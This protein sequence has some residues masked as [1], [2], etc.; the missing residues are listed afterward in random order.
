VKTIG[1]TL[2]TFLNKV[3]AP[4]P[5]QRN[6]ILGLGN[7]T[8]GP[9]DVYGSNATVF[10]IVSSLAEDTAAVGWCLH[11][12]FNLRS[13]TACDVC[14]EEGVVNAP[15]H[16]AYKLWMQPNKFQPGA[17]F[18]EASQQHVDLAGETFWMVEKEEFGN[19]PAALWIRWPH[20]MWEV[21]SEE[22]FLEGWLT[23]GQHGQKVPLELDEVL[24]TKLPNPANAYR[25]L[26]PV[27]AA[28]W[29]LGYQRQ[30]MEWNNAFF[31]NG[32]QLSGLIGVEGESDDDSLRQLRDMFRQSHQGVSNAHRVAILTRNAK[33]QPMTYSHKDMEFRE[34][35]ML[36]EDV[37]QKAFRY[38]KWMLGVPE[39]SNKASSDNA[40]T[41]Y[42]SKMLVP[43]LNRIKGTLNHG[44][45]PMYG[46][47]GKGYEFYFHNPVPEDKELENA[48]KESS[49]TTYKTL[50]DSGV[51]PEDAAM[52]AGLPPMR[53]RTTT[54]PE[55]VTA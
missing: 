7:Y 38:P 9:L 47:L 50:V 41:Y 48:T 29:H 52:V 3:P 25:G 31:R 34:M 30:A 40:D 49:A 6:S 2:S 26:G 54:V 36:S 14:G 21:P 18:R 55:G 28:M 20:Q 17:T 51:E 53:T 13:R 22:E 45:L 32:V 37:I 16:P 43:R 15:D 27:A 8:S 12:K 46:G 11:K 35:Y 24:H 33:F 4:H 10:P 5:V 39:G 19:L 1:Q 23:A 42:T 44:L